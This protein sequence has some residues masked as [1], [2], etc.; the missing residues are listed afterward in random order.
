MTIQEIDGF[1]SVTNSLIEAYCKKYPDEYEFDQCSIG[2]DPKTG[3]ISTADG[4]HL[5]DTLD[6]VNTCIIPDLIGE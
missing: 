4:E 3:E 5:G 1:V 2:Y 6:W